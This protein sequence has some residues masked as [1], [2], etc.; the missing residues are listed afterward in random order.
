MAILITVIGFGIM[1][2]IHEL[3]HFIAAKR[4]GVLVHEFAIGMGPKIFSFDKGE[5]KYSL[6]LF[7]I[8]G[9]VK[10]EGENELE[11]NDNPRSFSNLKPIKRIIILVA[12]AFMN[13]LLGF[14]IFTFINIKVG[15]TPSIVREIP[16]D[17]ASQQVNFQVGD[18]IIQLN[19]SRIHSYD[20]VSLF[21]I[22]YEDDSLD[23]TLK[24]NGEAIELDD[25][26]LIKTDSG[27]KLGVIFQPE[28]GSFLKCAEF[29]VYDTLHIS[30]AVI[31][32]LTDLFKGKQSLN[33]LSGPVEIVSTVNQVTAV[34]SDYTYLSILMLF[35]MIT[36]NLGIFNLLPFPALDGGSIIFA[37]YE[38]I[39][40][41]KVKSEIVGYAGLIGF[42]LLMLLA[43]YVTAGDIFD[44]IK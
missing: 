43:I 38:L 1:I 4:F 3:G 5:T 7:P 10:L 9:F 31:F 32:A 44:L 25:A 22:R 8:G 26:K 12:G 27:Y 29:A 15:I 20:D 35:A 33:S 2:F 37:L 41:K 16:E 18:E 34:E 19:D 13:V 11:E 17:L 6:R 40:R 30:K 39:T 42:A 23:I 21:M 14:L 24:R 28:K 36:V